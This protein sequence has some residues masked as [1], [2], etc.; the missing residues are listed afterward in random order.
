MS[1]TNSR[2]TAAASRA[3]FGSLRRKILIWS[4]AIALVPLVVMA[5]QGYHCA[6]QAI[7]ESA[8][9]RLMAVAASR[10]AWTETWIQ[11]RLTDMAIVGQSRDCAALVTAESGH[12]SHHRV[13]SYLDTFRQRAEAYEA[14]ALFDMDWNRIAGAGSLPGT[15]DSSIAPDGAPH[16]VLRERLLTSDGPVIGDIHR[17]TGGPLQLCLA[18]DLSN[19]GGDAVGYVVSTLRLEETLAPILNERTG[20]GESGT[21]FLI[22]NDG[23][24]LTVSPTA[25]EGREPTFP[26]GERATPFAPGGDGAGIYRSAFG[27]EVVG[28]QAWM[29][30]RDWG[31][32]AEISSTEALGWLGTLRTRAFVVGALTL[33]LVIVFSRSVAGQLSYPLR[34]LAS[35]AQR[36]AGGRHRERVDIREGTEVR[37]VGNAFNQMLDALEDS[38]RKRLHSES[39]AAIGRLSSSI[40]HEMRNPLSSIKVNVQALARFAREDAAHAELAEIAG[41]QVE[42]VE[43][44]LGELLNYGKPFEMHLEEIPVRHLIDEILRASGPRAQSRGIR[45]TVDDQTASRAAKVDR[46]RI[47]QALANLIEN[48]AQAAGD[49]GTVSISA[50]FEDHDGGNACVFRVSDSGAGIAEGSMDRLFHPFFTTRTDGVGLGLANVKK[51]VEYHGGTVSASNRAAGGAEFTIVLPIDKSRG[52]A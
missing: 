21:V 40:V 22:A 16:P 1:D 46:E 17:H 5:Y 12:P 51:I 39:L 33:M 31:I 23:S 52:E 15:G 49:G 20:L 19:P 44:M 3:P 43:R 9:E 18:N 24:V 26:S 42:R 25:G 13:C 28:G 6:R 8:E 34:A 27:G 48:G 35:A 10:R 30:D 2:D 14:I 36:I 45:I 41:G 37:E 50:A 11:E 29:T 38:H 7:I 47:H 4:L 32:V